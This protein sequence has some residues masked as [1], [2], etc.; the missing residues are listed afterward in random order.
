MIDQS[1][2]AATISADTVGDLF[3]ILPPD[4]AA[5]LGIYAGQEVDWYGVKGGTADLRIDGRP[6]NVRLADRS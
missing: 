1:H 2:T 5:I 3:M 4:D 6:F